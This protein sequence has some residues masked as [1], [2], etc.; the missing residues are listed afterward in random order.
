MSKSVLEAEVR[1]L[2]EVK[3]DKI[4]AV[5]YGRGVE[6]ENLWV[7]RKSFIKVFK[8]AGEST[9]VNLKFGEE[10]RSVLIHD[11]QVHPITGDFLHID[12][13]QVRMDEKIETDIELLFKGIAPAVKELGGTF[14]KSLDKLPIRCLPGDLIGHVD[15]DIASLKTFEDHI[16]V[17][18]L[19]IP[20]AIEV[21]I[22]EDT[23]VALV[24]PPRTQAEM[25]KLDEE[26]EGDI[27]QVE[28]MEE[29]TEEEGEE[30]GDDKKGEEAKPGEGE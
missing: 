26:V 23:V 21:L 15:I 20:D 18:D 1:K 22:D 27:S 24:T 13:Y 14:V 10:L 5:L 28:G 3:D 6:N 29:K 7:D 16:Y 25:D 17:K 2:K 30:G 8:E 9:L 19:S 4:P 12:F 11:S